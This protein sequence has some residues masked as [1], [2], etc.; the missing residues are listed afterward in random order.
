MRCWQTLISPKI[1]R[2]VEY[3]MADYG[4]AGLGEGIELDHSTVRAGLSYRF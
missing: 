2:R 1:G 4:D 3:L